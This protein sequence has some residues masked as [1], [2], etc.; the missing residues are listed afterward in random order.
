M[1]EFIR[2]FSYNL[3]CGVQNSIPWP[4]IS[5]SVS[6]HSVLY[7]FCVQCT[8]LF[9]CTMNCTVSVYNVLYCFCV[10][11][12]VLFLSTMYYTVSVYNVLYCFCVQCTVLFLC[13]MYCTVSVYMYSWKKN[14]NKLSRLAAIL[15][16]FYHLGHKTISS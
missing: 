7:C 12:T 15:E 3:V 1:A 16:P 8:V 10:Q 4:P 11:C 14:N 6:V 5:V 9:L 2:I 13:T